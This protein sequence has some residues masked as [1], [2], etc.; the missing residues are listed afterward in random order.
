M[1]NLENFAYNQQPLSTGAFPTG[2]TDHSHFMPL[3]N[4]SPTDAASSVD[5]QA[6]NCKP[7]QKD[8]IP[9][10]LLSDL[11]LQ[12]LTALT[13][14]V[15]NISNTVQQLLLSK[16][17]VPQKK[18]VKNLVSRTPE[19]HKSQH[20]SPEGS[21]YS[22]EPAGTPLSEPPSSTPQ[23]THAEPQEAD[24][25]SAARPAAAPPESTATPRPSPSPC[26]PVL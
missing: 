1:P 17:A 4:P 9:E 25:L 21:G 2:I 5:T 15:E 12:S 23:S 14:Q 13:S 11:S 26:L 20:C 18:G 3:L 6:S 22:A 8:K 10:N 16:A 7:L 19:Q 24:Y